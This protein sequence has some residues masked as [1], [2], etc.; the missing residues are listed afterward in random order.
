MYDEYRKAAGY[1][2]KAFDGKGFHSLRRTVG[3]SLVTS[4]ISLTDAAQLLGK[5]KPESMKKYIALDVPHL[6]ECA[7]DLADIETGVKA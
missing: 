6:K 7:L 1:E 3:T 4:D 2:R 5:I